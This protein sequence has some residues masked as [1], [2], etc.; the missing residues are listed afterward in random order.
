MLVPP[1]I[2]CEIT[3]RSREQHV[4]LQD[5]RQRQTTPE[6]KAIYAAGSGI[7]GTGSGSMSEDGDFQIVAMQKKA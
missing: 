7:E 5:A 2:G 1:E 6:F 3:L 4:A